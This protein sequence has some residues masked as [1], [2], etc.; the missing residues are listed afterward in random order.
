VDWL[1]DRRRRILLGLL[2]AAATLA[3]FWPVLSADFIGVDDGYYILR[4][5]RVRAGLTCGGLGWALTSGFQASWH[6]LTWLS[7]MLDVQLFGLGPSGFHRTN[8]LLHVAN[9]VLLFWFLQSN[10]ERNL[11]PNRNLNRNLNP[12]LN[13]ATPSPWRSLFVAALFALHPLHVEPV[14]WV[15]CRKDVLSGLFFLLTLLAYSKYVQSKNGQAEERRGERGEESRITHHV[16]RITLYALTLFLFAFGLMSKA[17]L[18]TVPCVLLLLDFWPLRRWTFQLEPQAADGS[19]SG[20]APVWRSLR[21]NLPLLREKV[22]FFVLAAGASI[23]A[24]FAMHGERGAP[25]ALPLGP[26]L[27]NGIS[28]YCKYL[29]QTFWPTGLT[30]YYP[31]PGLRLVYELHGKPYP[32]SAWLGSLMLLIL[33]SLWVLLHLK[34][35]PWLAVGWF[36]YVGT[37]VPVSGILQVGSH[38]MA[39]RY[40]YIPLIGIFICVVWGVANR[41]GGDGPSPFC[42]SGDGPSPPRLWLVGGVA[43]ILACAGIS[44]KQVGYWQN[45]RVAFEHAL[46]VTADPGMAFY[47][48]G[49]AFAEQG[50]R[51]VAMALYRAAIMTDPRHEPDAYLDLGALLEQEGKTNEALAIYDKA[52]RAMPWA[53]QVHN[54]LGNL[55]SSMGR[56]EEAVN[57]YRAALQARDDYPDAHYNLGVALAAQHQWDQ[58]AAQFAAVVRLKPDDAEAHSSLAETLLNQGEPVQAEQEFREAIRLCPTNAAARFQLGVLC[59]GENKLDE[60]L[61]QFRQAARL[62]PDWP[63]ALNAL[64]WLL[65]THPKAESRNGAEAVR[66]A[67]RACA[68]VGDREPRFWS[69]LDCAYA[70]AGRFS[71]AIATAEKARKLALAAGKKELAEAAETRLALYREGRAFHQ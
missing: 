29:A 16:S 51:R 36:W 14:A 47:H 66:L 10:F 22:P 71:E 3:V 45:D 53:V 37:L 20:L 19:D 1:T 2:L 24:A 34:R 39:D 28:A 54:H 4:N 64:A 23:A 58:A 11:T 18:V 59:A 60:A 50:N 55:F 8:L 61:A 7:Y 27:A 5:S 67:E 46:S 6:P 31:H 57:H 68:L 35:R 25:V 62:R 12:N 40:T 32:V 13:L 17:M 41:R 33:V 56:A 30:L 42:S 15:A 9:V 48:I 44:R 52:L 63:E 43:V 49:R 65:A 70:E 26:R 21:A 38:A 69:T